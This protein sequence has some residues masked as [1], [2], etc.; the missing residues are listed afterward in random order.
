LTNDSPLDLE[1][2]Q[3][4][5]SLLDQ[6]LALAP[7]D[8]DRWLST[9]PA[10]FS[11]LAPT[12]RNMLAGKSVET[13]SFLSRPVAVQELISKA[14]P[15]LQDEAG[16]LV[17][18]Y[19]LVKQI[20]A[21]GMGT[22][23]LADRSDGSLTRRV[24]L[25]LPRHSW[26]PGLAERMRRERDVLASLEHHH[27]ARL[28]DAGVT[29]EGR[30]YM[31]LEYVEGKAIDQ[32][33]QDKSA[34]VADRLG[35]FLQVAE[36]VSHAHARLIVH[37]DLKPSNILVTASGE[38][39]LLDF[40]V[41]K[42]LQGDA[43]RNGLTESKL[44]RTTGNALTLD[45]ASPE[46]IR[47]EQITVASDVYSLGIVL[48]ELLTGRRPYALKRES[49][50]ALEDAIESQE[51]PLVSAMT[52]KA[53]R[54]SLRGDMDSIVAKALKK[55]PGERY[56]SVEAF[57]G[58]V[59]R[60]LR[61]EPVSAQK[62]TRWYR[63]RKFVIRNA[64]S[65][66]AGVL[67]AAA[68]LAGTGI[69][70]WQTR[71]AQ[72]EASRALSAK[73][74]ISSIFTSAVPKT[75]V[76]GVVTASD[77]LTAA[78]PRIETEFANDPVVAAELGVLIAEGFDE[79]GEIEKVEAPLKVA[80]ERA[81]KALGPANPITI[82][83]KILLGAAVGARDFD[84]ALKILQEAVPY[85]IAGLPETAKQAV[86]GL[87]EEAFILAKFNRVEPSYAALRQGIAIGEKYLGLEHELTI[88]SLG[89]LSNTY[90]R[91]QDRPRMLE[92]AQEAYRRATSAFAKQRPHLILT[93]VERWY[94]DAL[95]ANG[96]PEDALPLLT[97][98]L[99]DQERLDGFASQRVRN[100]KLS[101]ARALAVA[102]RVKE[103]IPIMQD[104]IA[105]EQQQ[106][107][108]DTEDRAA[109][110]NLMASMLLNARRASEALLQQQKAIEIFNRLPPDK[111][112]NVRYQLLLARALTLSGEFE[113]ATAIADE[114][115]AS[116]LNPSEAIAAA[117]IEKAFIARMRGDGLGE[118]VRL[119]EFSSNEKA[120]S[121]TVNTKAAVA[122]EMGMGYLD[123]GDYARAESP[124]KSCL[125]LLRS[126]QTTLSVRSADC[127]M[128]NARLHLKA[129]RSAEAE[130]LMKQLSQDWADVNPNSPWHG[131]A[132]YWLAK[133]QAQSG[134]AA[135]AKVTRALA[136]SLLRNSPMP[137]HHKLD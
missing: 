133:A 28:Y 77:L 87:R 30:P 105:F 5:N 44:T 129:G 79:L 134:E 123:A 20:G 118:H 115:L 131:E 49:V 99:Q 33:C 41:A 31:A 14:T 62:D 17:G 71:V 51:V 45:Y 29:P 116:S 58:D 119:N 54:R 125:D 21:G 36:A 57:A 130:R 3:R 136:K 60:F 2:W 48:F 103:A 92:T 93:A 72:M 25:K 81:E 135:Q 1:R 94:A 13:S 69:A 84:L 89:S 27:I 78:V 117:Y 52:D 38:V 50:G 121:L 70:L 76:G 74:F 22:V 53:S 19:R 73:R 127:L 18:P 120:V 16:Q 128:G 55:A 35:L 98:V 68:I 106:N 61:G 91:F 34:N 15:D 137:V 132:L 37:R 83:G 47:S 8:R 101:L 4:L 46:Q 114:A 12:L 80:V 64:G 65:V 124:L 82:R 26:A 85:A 42:L 9:L 100:A 126:I 113:K 108:N 67:V 63:A 102:G 95:Q 104:V 107:A 110:A 90:S 97:Q 88:Y 111:D 32:Y 75:G 109:F 23:W 40:G 112:R 122:A 86:Y 43:S 24:A 59:R 6:G 7:E 66:A 11:D 56:P 96:R 39:R 10:S